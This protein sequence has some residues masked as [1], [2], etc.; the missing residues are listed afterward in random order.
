MSTDE[1]AE[2]FVENNEIQLLKLLST[3]GGAAVA[4]L[5]GIW[6]EFMATLVGI[7]IWLIDGVGRFLAE[8]VGE[9]LG[10]PARVQVQAWQASFEA[11]VSE[12]QLQPFILVLEVLVLVA[13]FHGLR[14]RGVLP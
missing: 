9:L 4:L 14:N 11:T 13:A 7:H 12:P 1:L 2:S 5:V 10:T 8:L 6:I 3:I